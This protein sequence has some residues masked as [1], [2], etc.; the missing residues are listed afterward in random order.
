MYLSYM[1]KPIRNKANPMAK[2]LMQPKYAQRVVPTK[3][4]KLAARKTKHKKKFPNE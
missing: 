2:D 4:D 3:R 1:K